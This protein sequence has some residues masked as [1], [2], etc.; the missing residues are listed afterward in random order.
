MFA[1]SV[2]SEINIVIFSEPNFI[3]LKDKRNIVLDK[4]DTCGIYFRNISPYKILN[5]FKGMVAA[6]F[7]DFVVVSI[8]ITPNCIIA[9]YIY[10]GKFKFCKM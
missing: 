4:D 3:L 7:Q 6:Y 9:E 10:I 5:K 1:T 8:Y 2:E